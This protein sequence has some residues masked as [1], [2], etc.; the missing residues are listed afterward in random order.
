MSM[1]A[2]PMTPRPILRLAAGHLRD[3]WQGIV[4]HL[5]DVVEEVDRT[6][7]HLSQPVPSRSRPPLHHLRQVDG[8]QVARLIGQER[9]LAA[10][11]GRLDLADLGGGVVLVEPVEKDDPRLAV[12]P[13]LVDD[14]G[15]HLA[16]FSVPAGCTVARVDEGVVGVL[17][18]AFMKASVIPTEMLKL[19][20]WF[21]SSLHMMKSMMS[22]WSTRSIAHVGAAPGAPL[23]DGLGG[24]VEDPHEGERA[25]GD[26]GGGH[27]HVVG[28][29][30]PRKGET[31]P[32]A[33]TCGSGR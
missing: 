5:D 9:L 11:V 17:F 13:R 23:L 20:R 12:L 14:P 3:L 25:A 30:Q 8:A 24:D 10:R 33:A 27:D 29:A 31:G 26:A 1:S 32:A 22:G 16:A 19:L 2:Q 15:E 6:A 21:W 7:H 18:T 4:V 28:R